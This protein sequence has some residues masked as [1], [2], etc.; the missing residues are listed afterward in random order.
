MRRSFLP[1][2]MLPVLA[3]AAGCGF[4]SEPT[5]AVAPLPVRVQDGAGRTVTVDTRPARIV[6]LDPG[7]TAWLYALGA[8]PRVVARSGAETYPKAA[9]KL[10]AI[11]H[12]GAADSGRIL[13]HRPD[14]VI[15]PFGLSAAN[16]ASLAR[17]VKAPVY[18]AGA[19]T[20]P[21]VQHDVLALAGLL[22]VPQRGQMLV[23][24]MR[25]QLRAVHDAVAGEHAVRVF[26][27]QGAFVTIDPGSIAASEIAAAGGKNAA[28]CEDSSHPLT[29]AQ[30]V[31]AAPGVYLAVPGTTTLADLRS[32]PATRRLPAV[33]SG[34]FHLVSAASLEDTGPRIAA[35]VR[36]LARI[37][38]P[39]SGV[40]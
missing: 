8:G 27:D 23:H 28:G 22:G 26:V 37:L 2:V 32:D 20:I 10:P 29:R 11:G 6:S 24:R 31:K 12:Q 40:R 13:A 18:V 33:R 34:N 15:A 35:A 36:R 39:Q 38:H 19:P 7:L 21:T 4:K 5:G 1:L 25:G 3:V 9:L 16:A 14:L 30:L 17:A